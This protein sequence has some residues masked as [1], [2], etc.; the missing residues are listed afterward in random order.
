MQNTSAYMPRRHVM[1]MQRKFGV[2]LPHAL[3]NGGNGELQAP[4]A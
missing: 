4:T 1:K 2:E 3:R